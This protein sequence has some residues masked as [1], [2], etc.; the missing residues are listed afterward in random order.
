MNENPDMSCAGLD[1]VAAEL[2]LG[3]LTG[4]ERAEAVAHLDRCDNC[5]EHV[6]QLMGTTEGLIGLLPEREPPAGFETRVLD[7]LGMSVP[8]P[9]SAAPN[10]MGPAGPHLLPSAPGR[11]GAPGRH[12]HRPVRRGAAPRPSFPKRTLAAAAVALAVVIAGLGGWGMGM[13]MSPRGEEPLS[14]TAFVTAQHQNVGQMFVYQGSPGWLYISVDLPPGTGTVK[15]Q[16]V[17]T[18]GR[19]ST[20]G[21]FPLNDNG[22]GAWGVP[23]PGGAS[24]TIDGARLVSTKG[25]LLATA[26]FG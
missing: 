24:G 22:Y 20:I 15:C 4:R 26:S 12:G 3:V 9:L 18:D 25:A 17:G 6:R 10:G 7:R 23:A 8:A 1:A 13:S 16:V 19:V 2:A 14:S 21:W 11:P 5:R